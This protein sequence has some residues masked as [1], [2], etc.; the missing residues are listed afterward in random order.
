M[1]I[2]LERPSS[3]FVMK[4]WSAGNDNKID[5]LFLTILEI[6]RLSLNRNIIEV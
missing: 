2:R 5:L 3:S 6:D 1:N 4:Y